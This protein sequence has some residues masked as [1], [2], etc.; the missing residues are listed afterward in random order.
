[1]YSVGFV[2]YLEGI[3]L[4]WEDVVDVKFVDICLNFELFQ[5][6]NLGDMVVVG[7][8][9]FYFRIQGRNLVVDGCFDGQV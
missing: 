4:L 1:M 2:F 6:I 5:N 8:Q 9:L 3:F 7:D